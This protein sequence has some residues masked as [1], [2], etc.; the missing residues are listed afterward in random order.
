M[1][2]AEVSNANKVA[3][4]AKTLPT[5]RRPSWSYKHGWDY[6]P[7]LPACHRGQ[8]R[9]YRGCRGQ[10]RKYGGHRG[11][12]ETT[13]ST[14]L[15]PRCGGAMLVLSAADVTDPIRRP[16]N[17]WPRI[18]SAADSDV[19]LA[20]TGS[21]RSAPVISLPFSQ[22]AILFL[23]FPPPIFMPFLHPLSC[24]SASPFPPRFVASSALST[25]HPPALPPFLLP[26]LR[27]SSFGGGGCSGLLLCRG[28]K[29]CDSGGPACKRRSSGGQMSE[30]RDPA[31]KL[32]GNT[33]QLREGQAAE[34][35]AVEGAD[36]A[37]AGGADEEAKDTSK[38]VSSAKTKVSTSERSQELDQFEPDVSSTL[39]GAEVDDCQIPKQEEGAV[40][41]PKTEH[42]QNEADSSSQQKVLKKPDKILPCPRCN[43]LDTKFCYYNNYNVNQPRH[44]C[45][46]CQRYW[47]AGGTM[48]NVPVGAGRRKNKHSASHYRQMLVSSEAIPSP[49][50][51]HPNPVHNQVTACVLPGRTR[52]SKGNGTVLK[53]GSDRPL[54]E[55]MSSVLNLEDQKK[56]AEMGP[57]HCGD[58]GEEPSCASSMTTLNGAENK[59]P[60][61]TTRMESNGVQNCCNGLTS[62]PP[63]HC[64]PGPPWAYPWPPGWNGVAPM[65]SGQCPSEIMYGQENGKSNPFAWN[66]PVMMAATPFCA[67]AIPVP[68]I[69]ASFWGCMSSW[70]NG[71]WNMPWIGST[72][73]ASLPS[74]ASN[75]GCSGNSSPTLGKHSRDTSLPGEDK[76]EKS[77]WVPKTLRIDDPDEAAKS[78]I[79]AT[80]GI[81]PDPNEST[82]KAGIFRAFQP[83]TDSKVHPSGGTQVLH[84]NPAALSR[85]QTFQEST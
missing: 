4:E 65:A 39:N 32:F 77:L 55:S 6:A 82:K 30:A 24:R 83:K 74:S 29:K 57:T 44:F 3:A 11:K 22:R 66:P 14:Q 5:R 19:P 58:N 37:P 72:G 52:H 38:E 18:A 40:G 53:F 70:P 20:P 15:P 71:V 59:F 31:M 25:P 46:N 33:I 10:Q 76:T 63:S 7:L 26:L 45:K 64:Y 16:E 47:T 8:Q 43:S 49:Q 9:K 69:P 62:L 17:S 84:V 73:G 60:D 61:N 80:L 75:D 1:I 2:L 41:D 48:R 28:K 50:V 85:S 21:S 81:K 35:A 34:E 13:H 42:E 36:P 51:D 27:I 67:P 79:W 23:P 54:C 78:S 68:F 12:P 56:S